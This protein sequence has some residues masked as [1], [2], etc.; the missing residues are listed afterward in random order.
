MDIEQ[1]REMN[2]AL[3]K[4]LAFE[5]QGNHAAARNWAQRLTQM[6]AEAFPVGGGVDATAAKR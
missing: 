1:R 2:R 6:L 4:A 5:A 3:A